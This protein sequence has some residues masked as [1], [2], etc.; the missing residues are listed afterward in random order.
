MPMM[1][2]T[3]GICA[4]PTSPVAPV[5]EMPLRARETVVSNPMSIM[6]Q[7]AV[8]KPMTP[9]PNPTPVPMPLP[10]CS[11]HVL[12]LAPEMQGM[13]A[14]MSQ[15]FLQTNHSSCP[16]LYQENGFF[17]PLVFKASNSDPDTLT[18]DEVMANTVNH[19]GWLEAAANEISALEAKGTWEEADIL[20]AESKILTGTWVFS[21]HSHH[22]WN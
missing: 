15:P 10:R 12:Q 18:F 6:K 14:R 21:C 7:M 4:S 9:T 20:Q 16:H 11:R 8:S 19:Q 17:M 5:P 13:L 3:P 1:P 22:T 2:M